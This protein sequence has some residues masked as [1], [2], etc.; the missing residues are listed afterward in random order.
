MHENTEWYQNKNAQKVNSHVEVR[1]GEN[2]LTEEGGALGSLKGLVNK[3]V[4]LTDSEE[5]F[6]EKINLLSGAFFVEGF[7]I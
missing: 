1:I 5:E 3:A 6:A 2:E 4:R 7:E